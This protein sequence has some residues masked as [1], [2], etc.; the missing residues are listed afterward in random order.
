MF[1]GNDK[2][3]L[4]EEDSV[5]LQSLYLVYH[6]YYKEYQ[7]I[8]HGGYVHATIS[9]TTTFNARKVALKLFENIIDSMMDKEP[10]H[11]CWD[12]C[13]AIDGGTCVFAHNY[14]RAEFQDCCADECGQYEQ[15]L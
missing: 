6:E 13:Y 14:K 10:Q 15:A 12:C 4:L 3:F 11:G 2:M 8:G 1:Q 9:I 5:D 7:I